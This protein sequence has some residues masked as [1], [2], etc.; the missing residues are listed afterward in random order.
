MKFCKFHE[1]DKV[2]KLNTHKNSSS[3]SKISM[4]QSCEIKTHWK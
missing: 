2:V 3:H 4:Y 1:Q